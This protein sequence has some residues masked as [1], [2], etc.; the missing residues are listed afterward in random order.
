MRWSVLLVLLAFPCFPQDARKPS[1]NARNRGRLWPEQA[2]TDRDFARRAARCG[3]LEMCTRG[4]WRYGWQ[5]L[6]VHVSQLGRGRKAEIVGCA[7]EVLSAPRLRTEEA[8]RPRAAGT[9]G[10]AQGESHTE[11]TGH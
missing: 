1:C 9:Q 4:V 8:S 3:E 11:A 7:S 6:T 2:N 10:E 5:P